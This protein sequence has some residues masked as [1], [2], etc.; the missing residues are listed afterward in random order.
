MNF[1]FSCHLNNVPT[2]T[3]PDAFGPLDPLPLPVSLVP[4]GSLQNANTRTNNCPA[5]ATGT[6]QCSHNYLR[7]ALLLSHSKFLQQ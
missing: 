5:P 1:F 2:R 4:E 6:I 3:V 7:L